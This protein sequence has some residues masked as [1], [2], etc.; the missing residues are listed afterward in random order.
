MLEILT[1]KIQK[2]QN[3][4]FLFHTLLGTWEQFFQQVKD[5]KTKFGEVQGKLETSLSCFLP[6]SARFYLLD[7]QRAF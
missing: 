3:Y 7:F 1:K 5:L 6:L 2:K 4:C